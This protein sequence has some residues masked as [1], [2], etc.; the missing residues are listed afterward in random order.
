MSNEHLEQVADKQSSYIVELELLLEKFSEHIAK[1]PVVCPGQPHM[2][3]DPGTLSDEQITDWCR[4]ANQ[5]HA[6]AINLVNRPAGGGDC[7]AT[8]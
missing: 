1:T 8:S 4:K 6:D 2:F 5:L 7:Q 3:V